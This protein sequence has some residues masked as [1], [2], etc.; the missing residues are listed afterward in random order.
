MSAIAIIPA[1]GGSVRIPRK[2]IRPFHGKPIIA[3]SIATAMKSS[4][5]REVVVT[6]DDDEIASVAEKYGAD[7]FHRKPDDGARGTQDVAA[8]VLRSIPDVETA[9]VIYATA[10]LVQPID[11]VRGKNALHRPG[12]AY[13]FS[14]GTAPLCD[15]GGFYWGHSWAFRDRVPLW[16][17]TTVMIPLPASRVCDINDFNDWHRAEALYAAL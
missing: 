5:F 17:E 11:L 12:V 2:N 14:V 6:T 7:V 9:C 4:L 8:E 15:A 3:Y 10:P 1:R 13:S 16:D